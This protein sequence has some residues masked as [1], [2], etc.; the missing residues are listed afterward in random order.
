VF[1]HIFNHNY[2]IKS[3]VLTKPCVLTF[4]ISIEYISLFT[5]VLSKTVRN[6]LRTVN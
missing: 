6:F 2:T 1:V 4:P 3:V 5:V